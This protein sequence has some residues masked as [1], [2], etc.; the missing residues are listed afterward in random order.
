[1]KLIVL[2]FGLAAGFGGGVWWGVHHPDQAANLSAEEERRFIE[3]QIKTSEA[4]KAKLDG[5]AAK[6]AQASTGGAKGF[7]SGFVSGNPGPAVSDAEIDNLRKDQD[8]QLQ[9]LHQRLDQLKQ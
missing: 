6:K 1:M 4:V 2:L 8:A 7:V 5:M 3:L 9:Q